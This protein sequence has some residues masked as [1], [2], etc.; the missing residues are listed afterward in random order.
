MLVSLAFPSRLGPEGG[1]CLALAQAPGLRL[2][3]CVP[4]E[5]FGGPIP[6]LAPV[7]SSSEFLTL[8]HTDTRGRI[9]PCRGVSC[10]VQA[11][12]LAPGL[13]PPAAGCPPASDDHQSC[14]GRCHISSRGQ[15][16]TLV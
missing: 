13:Y 4:G 5:A 10:A 6:G 2:G 9:T 7:S 12:K 11:A 3:F 14:L 15:D 16:H 1:L 8:S